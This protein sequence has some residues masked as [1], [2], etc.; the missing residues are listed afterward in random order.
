MTK[1]AD[2]E[3]RGRCLQALHVDAALHCAAVERF[4]ESCADHIW[5]R[6][7]TYDLEAVISDFKSFKENTVMMNVSSADILPYPSLIGIEQ[8]FNLDNLTQRDRIALIS[9]IGWRSSTPI[10]Y[11][12]LTLEAAMAQEGLTPM[13]L[14]VGLQGTT[15]IRLMIAAAALRS[16]T[17]LPDDPRLDPKPYDRAPVKAPRSGDEAARRL[18]SPTA[19]AGVAGEY[20]ASFVPNPKRKGSAAFDRYALYEVGLNRAQLRER[21]CTASDFKYDTEHGFVTWRSDGPEAEEPAPETLAAA[22][23]KA[24]ILTY[25]DDEGQEHDV[26]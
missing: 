22:L 24:E 8:G 10:S 5:S 25:N 1:E 21:G 23:D 4:G 17:R 15:D 2:R 12:G 20:L 3:A 11:M 26:I 19:R 13:D 16:V 14:W 9:W 6:I 7:T 18:R